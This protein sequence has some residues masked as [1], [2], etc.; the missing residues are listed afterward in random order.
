MLKKAQLQQPLPIAPVG[1]PSQAQLF[2]RSCSRSAG[3]TQDTQRCAA[4]DSDSRAK[5]IVI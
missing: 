4:D 2:L 5:V 3:T 1:Q